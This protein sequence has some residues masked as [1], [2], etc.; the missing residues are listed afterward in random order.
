MSQKSYNGVSTLYLIA[1]PIGNM[2]DITYRAIETLK[3]VE[4][5]FS[6][7]TRVTGQLLKHFDIKKK[8]ISNDQHKES[9]NKLKLIEYLKN[10]YNVGLVTDRGTPI[11]SDPGY[12]L[13]KYA[14]EQEYNVVAIPGATALIPALITSGITTEP[15]TFFGFLNSKETKR[16]KELEEIKKM[17]TT[18]IFYEAPHRILETL[19]NILEI[20]GNRNIAVCREITKKY[21]EIY[22]GKVTDVIKKIVDIKGEIVIVVEKDNTPVSYDISIIEH[23]NLYIKEGMNSKEAIKQVAIDRGIPKSIVYNEYHGGW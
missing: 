12:E 22:R 5:I 7:D 23:I 21:E 13:V 20:L 15:F 16:K 8:L 14:I 4:V 17:K 18:L 1:T 6:E 9:K 10:G 19:N 2:Q 3:E 11:V